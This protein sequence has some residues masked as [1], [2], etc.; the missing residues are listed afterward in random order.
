MKI[1][2]V[3]LL[4]A[5][6]FAA[7]PCKFAKVS[8]AELRG[9]TVRLAR[10]LRKLEKTDSAIAQ[11]LFDEANCLR[12]VMATRMETYYPTKPTFK[13]ID[14]NLDAM[15]TELEWLAHRIPEKVPSVQE[16]EARH[17]EHK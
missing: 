13:A 1:L 9:Q 14:E 3:L 5:S 6:C 10:Q 2:I 11:P 16:D 12:E 7:E 4:T 15:I 8:N 17:R